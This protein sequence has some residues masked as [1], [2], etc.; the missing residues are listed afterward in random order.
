MIKLTEIAQNIGIKP[1]AD[2]SSVEN[3]SQQPVLLTKDQKKTLVNEVA[4]YNEYGKVLYEYGKLAEIAEKLSTICETAESYAINECGDWMEANVVK[5]HFTEL[6]KLSE[7]FNKLAKD[8]HSKNIQMTS[9]YEDIGNILEKYF[10]INDP[11]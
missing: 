2:Q 9:L 6:K 11:K 10:E 3:P 4:N 8:C 7:Q 1:K 5:R